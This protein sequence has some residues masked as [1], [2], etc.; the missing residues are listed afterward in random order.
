MKYYRKL[1]QNISRSIY[2][3][4]AICPQNVGMQCL[5][6]NSERHLVLSEILFHQS[7][8]NESSESES[9]CHVWLFT[10]HGLYTVHGILHAR[11]LEW[12]AFPFTRGSSQPRDQNPGLPH[13]KWILY[14]QS[15]K[16]SPR[17]LEWVAEPFSKG[18]SPPRNQTG[19]SYIEGR[20]FTNGDI[21]EGL[22]TCD[23]NGACCC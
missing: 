6:L 4:G 5:I 21:R 15:H 19:V 3:R 18:S 14:Q 13:C 2:I 23:L 1:K 12:V 20:F 22:T 17:I 7:I 11:I 16:G 8:Y 10:T 9:R